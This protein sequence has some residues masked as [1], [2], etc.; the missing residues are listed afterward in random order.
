MSAREQSEETPT[1]F[2][3]VPEGYV[4][5]PFVVEPNYAG[6]RLDRYLAEKLRRLTR[7]RLHGIIQR[8]VLCEER[9]LKS[10]TPVYPGLCFRIRRPVS[11]EPETPTEL[12]VLFQ[13]DWLLV[14]DKP[15]G[16]P[17]HPTA[18]Y[19][20]GTLVSLLRERFGEAFAEPAHR[21][22]RETSGLVVCGRTT[23]SCRVLGRLFVSRDVDKE[24][25]AVCEG[26]PPGDTFFVD[27]PIAEGTELIRIAVR[28]D[29]V[30]GK[31]SRT[32]FQV[33]Q[34]FSRDGEPFSL[35]RCYPETGR[36]HQI[37]IHLREAGFPLVGDKMYG[38]DPG[39]FDRF[40]KHCLEPEA[41]V[42]LRL[43]RHALHAA[44]ISFPHP[45]TGESV[46]FD[47]P[48][49][50]DLQ[51]FIDGRPLITGPASEADAG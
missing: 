2:G 40:S 35:L 24:Y 27:A 29:P 34:R 17:I 11:A 18:R 12:P 25:L 3:E 20:K 36:Q 42:R 14:L 19:H 1:P 39:Y 45:G 16:L 32:R 10:S 9:R 21:L 33:L 6:W 44:R 31:E 5:I 37:R 41:W 38:P 48:L 13:D 28:I 7:E 15:A 26:H 47:S 46:A 43:P 22:D 50:A 4:D 23:E 8:G 49:P 30:E 51:D